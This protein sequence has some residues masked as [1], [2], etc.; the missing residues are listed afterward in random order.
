M[1]GG[2]DRDRTGDPLLAK[3]ARTKNQQLTPCAMKYYG[4]LQ[5]QRFRVLNSMRR[6]SVALGR[7]GGGHKLGH[8]SVTKAGD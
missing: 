7:V 6:Y 5:V 3:I 4:M 8:M 2:R 1:V